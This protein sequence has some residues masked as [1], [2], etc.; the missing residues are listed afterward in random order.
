MQTIHTVEYYAEVCRK[1]G[2]RKHY[3]NG[4]GRQN[5]SYMVLA[6]FYEKSRVNKSTGTE[7]RRAVAWGVTTNRH[8]E[9]YQGDENVLK[10]Y[11]GCSQKF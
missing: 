2:P 10:L 4:G 8:E 9:S 7:R 1:Y 11:Y 6:H 3:A 5:R